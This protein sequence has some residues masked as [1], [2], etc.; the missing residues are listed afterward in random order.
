MEQDLL[1]QM[2]NVVSNVIPLFNC[3]TA[4]DANKDHVSEF[5]RFRVV[6]R[7]LELHMFVDQKKRWETCIVFLHGYKILS[8]EMSGWLKFFTDK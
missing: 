2:W 4:A 1:E 7:P 5:D 3:K 8:K 6:L